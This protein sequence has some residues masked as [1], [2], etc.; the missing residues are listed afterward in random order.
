MY[1]LSLSTLGLSSTCQQAPSISSV[2]H[3]K[4]ATDAGQIGPFFALTTLEDGDEDESEGERSIS[5]V[6]PGGAHEQTDGKTRQTDAIYRP[7]CVTIVWYIVITLF[8]V[9]HAAV[10]DNLIHK[11]ITHFTINDINSTCK[12][13]P[14]QTSSAFCGINER[15][16]HNILGIITG[17]SGA[18]N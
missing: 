8:H 17:E 10:S 11:K 15:I 13:F 14:L 12:H 9:V 1:I 6:T 2:T 18:A 5:G 7:I 4:H 16:A 3:T